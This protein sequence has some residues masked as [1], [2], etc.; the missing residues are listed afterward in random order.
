[1]NE[2]VQFKKVNSCNLILTSLVRFTHHV[3]LDF[4]SR[5]QRYY[6]KCR[7]GWC[8]RIER[9][10]FIGREYW[11]ENIRRLNLGNLIRLLVLEHSQ[12]RTAFDLLKEGM[13][14]QK[15]T[16]SRPFFIYTFTYAT[17]VYQCMKPI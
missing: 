5:D 6:V 2:Y 15:L 16:L 10:G 17:Y 9:K 13:I 7:R 14:S 3:M 1:M 4:E 11:A 8:L 12:K